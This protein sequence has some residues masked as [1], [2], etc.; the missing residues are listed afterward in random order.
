MHD[1]YASIGAFGTSCLFTDAF[2]DPARPEIRGLRYRQVYLGE[3][4]YA[5]NH[6]GQVDKVF[7]RFKMTLRQLAQKFGE[8]A[9]PPEFPE[10]LKLNPEAEHFVIHVVQPNASYEAGTLDNR[11][12]RFSSHYILLEQKH[13]LQEGGFRTFPYAIS[14]YVLAP[15][16]IYGRGPAMNVLPSINVLNEEKKVILKAGHRAVDPVLL[17]HDDGIL[18]GFSLK[19]GALNSGAVS[20][21]GRPLVHPLPVGDMNIG[22]ELLDDERAVINDA[23]LVT[24]FQILVQTPQMTATEV[25]ERAREKGALLSPTMGRFQS[26]ALEIGRA[27]CRERV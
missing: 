14:R 26:E 20:S 17:V 24:L 11:A 27:S 9:L 3:L 12:F 25:I 15:G 13:L 18:D 4:F 7:R 21:D 8:A 22:K 6:Q 10:K 23:F 19:P 5:V 1:G 2:R 16:E